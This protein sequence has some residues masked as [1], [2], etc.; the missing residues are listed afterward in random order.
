MLLFSPA[1]NIRFPFSSR[2]VPSPAK[3]M[4]TM[5]DAFMRQ[6]APRFGHLPSDAFQRSGF[7]TAAV[8]AGQE[9]VGPHYAVIP[10]T[11]QTTSF[12]VDPDHPGLYDYTRSGNPTFTRLEK[13]LS[14]L[15]GGRH[16]VVFPSGLAAE[17]AL[18]MGAL[19]RGDELIIGKDKYGGTD[20]LLNQVLKEKYDLKVH[21]VD[22]SKSGALEAVI[23]QHPKA[24]LLY[25]ESLTNPL[26]GVTDIAEA[27]RTAR[28]HGL[29]TCVDNTF[30]SPYLIRPLEL[31]AD[32]VVESTTKYINGHS[33]VTGGAIIT[34]DESVA[35]Q[36]GYLRNALGFTPSPQDVALIQRGLKTLSL[37]MERQ[38]DNALKV[39]RFLETHPAV[40][41]VLYPGLP[42]H[43]GH[44]IAKRQMDGRY[45]G[46]LSFRLKGTRQDATEFMRNCKVFFPAVSLGAVE[47]LVQYPGEMSHATVKAEDKQG[48]GN[49]IRL[50]IGI[51]DADDLIADL[52]QALRTIKV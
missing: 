44:D 8:H 5:P 9:P 43:P 14:Q 26:L 27:T 1:F 48:F 3:A 49:L 15:E 51:E 2:E 22:L 40:E 24:K 30:A 45:G 20:R 18:F 29:K 36:V 46:V 41:A 28:R 19:N 4:A 31:G 47:S 39:A 42:S 11:E 10:P 32:I 50:A 13:T 35:R 34:N 23:R 37:R 52:G 16:A 38:S 21:P 12:K 25:L 17:T 33:D 6:S 7:N